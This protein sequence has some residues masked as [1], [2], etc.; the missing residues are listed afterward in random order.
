MNVTHYEIGG[1]AFCDG[2]VFVCANPQL[3]LKN[4]TNLK[5]FPGKKIFAVEAEWSET[6]LNILCVSDF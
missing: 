5:E 1:D 4:F 2:Y 3:P 6:V